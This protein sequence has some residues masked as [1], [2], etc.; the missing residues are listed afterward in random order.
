MV[1]TAPGVAYD[2]SSGNIVMVY[3]T[4]RSQNNEGWMTYRS[5]GVWHSE[6]ANLYSPTQPGLAWFHG[7]LYMVAK[8]NNGDNNNFIDNLDSTGHLLPGE[9]R[10][11]T[12][13]TDRGYSMLVWNGQLT[14][15]ARKNGGNFA[16]VVYV[17]SDAQNWYSHE[18][19]GDNSGSTPGL[20]L[21]GGGITTAFKSGI[22]SQ[23]VLYAAHSN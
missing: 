7:N 4:N 22:S 23:Y 16:L 1:I 3:G 5:N 2:A 19:D 15:A 6:D 9:F 10:Q 8:Q 17:S 20:V 12:G 11:I 14:F 18:Y 21:F 13:S